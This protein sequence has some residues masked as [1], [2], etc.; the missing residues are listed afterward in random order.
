VR[1]KQNQVMRAP[2]TRSAA[3]CSGWRPRA[4]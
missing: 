1:R 2:P 4:S 3:G